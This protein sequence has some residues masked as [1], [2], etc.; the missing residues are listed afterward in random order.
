MPACRA[1]GRNGSVIQN[2]ARTVS[3]SGQNLEMKPMTH[4]NNSSSKITATSSEIA[5]LVNVLKESMIECSN[6][7]ANTLTLVAEDVVGGMRSFI[8]KSALT[9]VESFS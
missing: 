7:F 9:P 6:L 4:N 5:S 3:T 1:G 8:S 2:N